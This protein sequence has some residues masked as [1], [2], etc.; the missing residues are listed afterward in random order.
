MEKY[1]IWH[2]QGGLGKNIASTALC[3]DIKE[4]Y[5]DRQFI[6]VCTYPEIFS[7]NPYVDRVFNLNKLSYFYKDYIENKDVIIFKH[8]PCDTT[9]HIKNEKHIIESWSDIL[10]IDY[11]N[12]HPILYLNYAQRLN[13]NKW[14]RN[15]PILILHTTGGPGYLNP[16]QPLPAYSW[17]RDLPYELSQKI[18][19]KYHLKYHIIH[20][21]RPGG[22]PLSNVE[23]IEN[24][25]DVLDLIS[26]VQISQKRI[27]IDSS[28]QH[29]SS[30]LN[31]QS[32]VIWIGTD[33]KVYGYDIHNNYTSSL[34]T[35]LINDFNT[36]DLKY[37]LAN[38][39]NECPFIS[40]DEVFDVKKLLTQL[41]D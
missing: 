7:N 33:P 24:Q 41:G 10:G 30:S 34:P 23:R 1:L 35:S 29:L 40:L 39:E 11:N 19:D 8:D 32:E 6:L 5:P 20:L 13:I 9:G 4:K 3:K 2:V 18:V 21:T 38:N 14:Y 37:E 26:L 31:I 25:L 22:Y 15:K 17:A 27:L 16:L 12:Q 36:Y 28:L